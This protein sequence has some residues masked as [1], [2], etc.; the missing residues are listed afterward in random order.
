MKHGEREKNISTMIKTAHNLY[1]EVFQLHS[2]NDHLK[3]LLH[4][5][6]ATHGNQI[7]HSVL[8]PEEAE[9]IHHTKYF[10]TE[11]LKIMTKQE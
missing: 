9:K 1:Y 7:D 6:I 4:R 11:D 5:M 2:E 8:T 3:I 10:L